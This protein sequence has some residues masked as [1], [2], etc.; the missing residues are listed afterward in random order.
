MISTARSED[1]YNS[2]V[3]LLRGA[4]ALILSC[5]LGLQPAV[6][7]TRERGPVPS[8]VDPTAALDGSRVGALRLQTF[9]LT[10]SAF[11][12]HGLF[13]PFPAAAPVLPASLAQ[14]AQ[15]A[16]PQGTPAERLAHLRVVADKDVEGLDRASDGEA[17]EK[18]DD[19]FAELTEEPLAAAGADGAEAA[20]QAAADVPARAPL[21]QPTVP[22]PGAEKTDVP[23][24]P[25]P[26]PG[27]FAPVFRVPEIN[28]SFWTF[29]AGYGV[30]LLGFEMYTVGLPFT[31]TSM[32]TN[33]L[34]E[35]HDARAVDHAAAL[36]LAR[37]NRSLAR[38]AHW[39][40]QFVSY[41][42]M[43][44]FTRGAETHGP[45]KW[46]VRSM[47]ICG[48]LLVGVP[49]LFFST[50]VLGVAAAMALFCVVV[51][52]HSFFQGVAVTH[53][54][55]GTTRI[56]GDKRVAPEERTRANS[57]LTVISGV[58]SI[59]GPI[60][61][62][63]L[64]KI[65]PVMGKTGVGGAA[66][67]GLY[68]AARGVAGLI[69]ARV[70]LFG[71]PGEAAAA[72]SAAPAGL[73][74]T[75][76]DLAVSIKDGLGI[77][78]R[79][80]LLRTM[81][82]MSLVNS[83]FADPL[84]FNVLPEYVESLMEQ[85]ASAAIVRVPV[86]DWLLHGLISTPMGNFALM[87]DMASVGSIAAAMSI[88][89]LTSAFQKMGFKTEEALTVPFYFLAALEGPLFLLM[90]RVPT[91]IGTVGLYGLQAFV[92]GF[93]G[94][95][96]AGLYQKKLGDQKAGDVN[97]ILAAT[98]L[99]GIAAALISTFVYGFVLK[100]IPIGTS[101]AI[102]AVATCA[103]SVLRL[104]VPFLSFTRDQRRPPDVALGFETAFSPA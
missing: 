1:V 96:I 54:T 68:A 52:L 80:P 60:V 29:A 26:K 81:L 71:A 32:V 65:G 74:A 39:S 4:F 94:I 91:I 16:A 72:P 23:A 92:V 12:S 76:K 53:E 25:A 55:A 19:Q 38:M 56:F 77:V 61:A 97:K 43:P 83:L 46:L 40:G 13:A 103:V 17:R 21:D 27:F 86:L 69:Y 75:L 45:R 57:I 15:P 8:R 44:L 49:V 30:F 34:N 64:A 82:L 85:G 42:L 99:V 62:G 33:A 87:V 88:H 37:T 47:L 5:A 78:F 95:A 9:A 41:A 10:S 73:G 58:I 14:S 104:A 22:V 6:A 36:E 70:A 98:S 50:G 59:I 24:P 79:E 20:A 2:G 18:A 89:P 67:F 84:I 100:N 28:R 7:A 66:I 3:K 31:I 11:R 51:G 63:G 48:A 35:K 101:L 90:T 102:A 93:S